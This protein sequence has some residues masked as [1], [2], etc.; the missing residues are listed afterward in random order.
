MIK[1]SQNMKRY[2]D[3]HSLSLVSFNG[4]VLVPLKRWPSV[5]LL[6]FNFAQVFNMCP[7]RHLLASSSVLQALAFW[8]SQVLDL[9]EA[10][11]F[12]GFI[13]IILQEK[14]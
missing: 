10:S 4:P 7:S 8:T 9:L 12:S 5:T 14:K 2:S 13:L 11:D 3:K 1:T 6:L